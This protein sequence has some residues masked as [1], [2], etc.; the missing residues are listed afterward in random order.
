MPIIANVEVLLNP[1]TP[2][3]AALRS[4]KKQMLK[5][6]TFKEMKKRAYYEKP[7]QKKRRKSAEARKKR[8]KAEKKHEEWEQRVENV[9]RRQDDPLRRTA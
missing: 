1:F 4:L 2:I 5:E 7:S 9:K 3:D 8:R 6:G